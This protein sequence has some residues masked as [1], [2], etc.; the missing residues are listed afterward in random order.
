MSSDTSDDEY[1]GVDVEFDL[2]IIKGSQSLFYMFDDMKWACHG[3]TI[4]KTNNA[5][6]CCLGQ[7]SE[8]DSYVLPCRHVVHTRCLH[9]WTYETFEK[10]GNKVHCPICGDNV[11]WRNKQCLVCSKKTRNYSLTCSKE[12]TEK[13]ELF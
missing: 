9:R 13:L 11:N 7:N 6:A 4:I 5:C 3:F 10:N 8:W 2:K 1:H 12:C